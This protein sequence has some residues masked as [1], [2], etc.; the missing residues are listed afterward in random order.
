MMAA[1]VVLVAAGV[2]LP[3]ERPEGAGLLWDGAKLHLLLSYDPASLP[4]EKGDSTLR[5]EVAYQAQGARPSAGF[6]YPTLRREEAW[7]EVDLPLPLIPRD[8]V[9]RAEITLYDL[10]RSRV[11][12]RFTH[13]FRPLPLAVVPIT[14]EGRLR[15]PVFTTEDTLWFR[16]VLP[17]PGS[18]R[19]ELRGRK[20]KGM[21]WTSSGEDTVRKIPVPADRL[22]D[23][24][25]RLIAHY[26]TMVQEIRFA[27]WGM[28]GVSDRK[29]KEYVFLLQM[30]FPDS[31]FSGLLKLP[32]E[33]RRERFFAI[34]RSTDPNPATPVLEHYALFRKKLAQVDRMFSVGVIPGYRTH[35]GMVYL[36]YGPPDW[37]ERRPFAM[38]GRPTEVWIYE[39]PRRMV[40]VFE[41]RQGMGAYTLVDTDPPGI[42]P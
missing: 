23:G 24:E 29:W 19:V 30:A 14:R 6:L 35:Q 16:V 40:F 22:R 21:V 18:L 31:N 1:W 5:M 26:G 37:I 2:M 11:F 33:R 34:W 32:P 10:H 12:L 9:V 20:G 41:D 39:G 15:L 8:T 27:L 38:E 3:P 7:V 25:Y 42:F 17:G 28:R 13:T 36:K 4:W